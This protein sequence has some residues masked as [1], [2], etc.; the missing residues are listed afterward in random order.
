MDQRRQRKGYCRT[1]NVLGWLVMSFDTNTVAKRVT[2][3]V[4]DS[5]YITR[6]MRL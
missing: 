5:Y 3:F 1:A 6:H 4:K 2:R